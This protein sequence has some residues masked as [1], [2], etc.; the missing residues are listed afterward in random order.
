M[1]AEYTSLIRVEPYAPTA[2][3][4]IRI[5]RMD[6]TVDQPWHY[7]DYY[8]QPTAAKKSRAP[9]ICGG[10]IETAKSR[11]RDIQLSVS[12]PPDDEAVCYTCLSQMR[13]AYEPEMSR[14]FTYWLVRDGD[15]RVMLM[16]RNDLIWYAV[17]ID[18]IT[19]ERIRRAD[20]R[21]IVSDVIASGVKTL[22]GD[23]AR[24]PDYHSYEFYGLRING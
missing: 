3:P 12:D 1:S 9:V 5:A 8:R 15:R 21:A 22:A 6:R 4:W 20:P 18:G 13:Q 23:Q 19:E 17:P 2:P 10:S 14:T 7:L 16:R 24:E 11:N